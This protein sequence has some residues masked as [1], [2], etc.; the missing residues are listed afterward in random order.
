MLDMFK[1]WGAKVTFFVTGNNIG[2]GQIDNNALPWANLIKRMY[3]EG[4]Q[5]A[6]HTWSHQDLSTLTQSQRKQQMYSLE[7]AL[8]NV[9]GFFPTYMRPPYSSCTGQCQTDMADLGYHVTYFDLDTEDYLNDSPT[10]IQKP[11]DNFLNSLSKNAFG[12]GDWL[13]IGHD[14][15][16][17]TAHNLTEYMLALT[18]MRSYRAVTLGECLG[19]PPSNWYRTAGG[20]VTT[21]S[22]FTP[23]PPPPPSTSTPAAV[24]GAAPTGIS[25]EGSCAGTTGR[26]CQ[27]ST[28]GNCCSDKG[29]W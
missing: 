25:I 27:G 1:S 20:G 8:R 16:E 6:S 29:W 15:H 3:N 13:V 26:T 10:M 14:I 22:A 24:P 17:Q 19:D 21:S 11:K 4:H 9:L 12:Q 5:I 2:K 23:A 7:M 18:K 28:F